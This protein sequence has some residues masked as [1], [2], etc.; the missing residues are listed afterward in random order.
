M[1]GSKDL[2]PSTR[3]FGQVFYHNQFKAKPNW[4]SPNEN[5]SGK[6]AIVTG[7][8]T[9][10]GYEAA[11]Q[12]LDLKLSYLILGCRSFERG[13]SAAAKLRQ[14][15]P[16]AK[17]EVW[18]LDM[19]SYE[20]VQAF[21]QR[22]DTQLE[23][24]DFVLLNAGLFP[25]R[26]GT[27]PST[28]HEEGLQVNYISTV[29]LTFLLLPTLKAKGPLRGQEP[30]HLTIVNAALSL[31]AK[32][33][34]RNANPILPSFDN[35]KTFNMQEHY[36]SNKLLAHMFLWKLVDYVSADDVVVNLAD[37]AWCKGTDLGRDAPGPMKF[38]AKIFGS[39]TGRTPRVGAS[40]FV[41]ALI[42]KKKESHGCFLMS[43]EIHPFASLLYTTEGKALTQRIWDET[44]A[45]L[46]FAGVRAILESMKAQ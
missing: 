36:H 43:W 26:F 38:A 41:D 32:L 1:V 10:L 8:N 23:R 15:H 28:G 30:A 27:V 34:D 22:V 16:G 6:T 17:I 3:S 46:E 19:A 42:N 24:I 9:G 25:L 33:P 5:L 40:C 18:P 4:P 20:S 39:L 31:V 14:G 21:A 13:E 29:L 37:P 45:E 7:G 12:L 2:A 44:L 35:A 11:L